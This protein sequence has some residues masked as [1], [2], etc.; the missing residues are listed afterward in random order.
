MPKTYI[1][2]KH[3]L[4]LTVSEISRDLLILHHTVI[5]CSSLRN[6]ALARNV[7]RSTKTV[8]SRIQRIILMS[9][10][11]VESINGTTTQQQVRSLNLV[12]KTN[13][14]T[15]VHNS[16]H[17]VTTNLNLTVRLFST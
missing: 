3:F 17:K 10:A 4:S 2:L 11:Q 8:S 14:L 7:V 5:P 1:H 9:A 13:K 16:M 6:V 12:G 15:H